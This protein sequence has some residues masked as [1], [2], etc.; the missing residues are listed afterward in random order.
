MNIGRKAWDNYI[1][2]LRKINDKA[3]SEI[4]DA[5]MKYGVDE[6][7]NVV[8]DV[9]SVMV[10]DN[11]TFLEYCYAVTKKYGNASAAMAAQ[12]YDAIAELEK[13]SVPAA[14]MADPASL[15]DVAR[16]INGVRKT[17]S[18]VDEMVGALSRYVKK[19]GCDTTL[20]NAYRDRAQY[21]W[22]PHGD[23]C[24]YCMALAANGWT[25]V[26]TAKIRAGYP[27]EEHIHS[28]CDCTY[29][30]RFN[31]KT[32]V[33]G[34]NPDKYMDKLQKATADAGLIDKD[35]SLLKAFKGSGGQLNPDVINSLRK[36]N[37]AKNRERI[38]EQKASAYEKRKELNSSAAE[39]SD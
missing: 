18:N 30:I 6:T 20:K 23:T 29:A 19:A 25:N 24:A 17:S 3:A 28:N 34:Y 22:I 35:E 10:G 1:E 9:I 8:E 32:N 2:T 36:Q 5:L 13:A 37:Y 31:S 26:S 7:G 14:E 11:Q 4:K 12:M 16:T 39:E 21:A 15:N 33:S 38:L 27:H